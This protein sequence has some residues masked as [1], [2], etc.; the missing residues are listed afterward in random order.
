MIMQQTA[1]LLLPFLDVSMSTVI[2]DLPPSL[3]EESKQHIAMISETLSEKLK[4]FNFYRTHLHH[5]K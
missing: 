4:V 2:A 5:F 3:D 1:R